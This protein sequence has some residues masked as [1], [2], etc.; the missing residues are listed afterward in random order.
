MDGQK[1]KRQKENTEM[2]EPTISSL[3]NHIVSCPAEIS[4]YLEI[5]YLE[6][7]NGDVQK[8]RQHFQRILQKMKMPPS[9]TICRMNLLLTNGTEQFRQELQNVLDQEENLFQNQNQKY[10]EDVL[11]VHI[12][13]GKSHLKT[14]HQFSTPPASLSSQPYQTKRSHHYGWPRKFKVVVCDMFCGEAV[15]RGAN[16]FVKGILCGDKGI[17]KGDHV[18]VYANIKHDKP[19]TRG[20]FLE[21]YSGHCIFLGI[22][23]AQYHRAQMFSLERGVGIKMCTVSSEYFM[24]AVIPQPSLNGQLVGKMMLQNLP[25]ALVAHALDPKRNDVIADLCAAPGGKTSHVASLVRN[26]AII[27]AMDKSRKKVVSMQYFFETMGATCITPILKDSTRILITGQAKRKSVQDILACAE[28]SSKDGLLEVDGFYSESFDRIVLDP[29][30]SAL[31]LRPKLNIPIR[32]LKEL[33]RHGGYGK[34]LVQNAIELLKV[35]GV[36]TYSTCTIN[37]DENESMVRHVIDVYPSMELLP[38][39][40]NIGGPGLPGFGLNEQQRG[41]VR[42]FDPCD[43]AADTMGFFVAKFRKQRSL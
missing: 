36:M 11:E 24:Q 16:I 9:L 25:S 21:N 41:M 6:L 23:E 17:V 39:D 7:H 37:A 2:T 22:G 20:M 13:H 28:K 31:G 5:Q 30:C 14:L 18:A 42:R 29:P 33:K 12:L 4:N 15:L 8:S 32:S 1:T 43:E 40:Y 34:R 26:D 27:V 19:L 35:G 10:F 38:I 3:E